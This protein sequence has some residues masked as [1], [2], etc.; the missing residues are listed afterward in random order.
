MSLTPLPHGHL[1]PTPTNPQTHTLTLTTQ[2]AFAKTEAGWI[3]L[4]TGEKSNDGTTAVVAVVKGTTL[5]VMNVGDSEA[6]LA[7][8]GEAVLLTTCHNPAK[9]P[10]M[11]CH[12]CMYTYADAYHSRHTHSHA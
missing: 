8:N 3:E 1:P 9:N 4:A 12:S 2:N 11:Y 7:R 5:V 10:G 6:V